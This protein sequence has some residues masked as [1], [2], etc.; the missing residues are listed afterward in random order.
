MSPLYLCEYLTTI[1]VKDTFDKTTATFRQWTKNRK[2]Q[3]PTFLIFDEGLCWR[4]RWLL[5][6]KRWLEPV[7]V[8]SSTPLMGPLSVLLSPLLNQDRPM[9]RQNQHQWS[10][11]SRRQ[12]Q[13]KTDRPILTAVR[14]RNWMT[15]GGDNVFGPPFACSISAAIPASNVGRRSIERVEIPGRCVANRTTAKW[16]SNDWGF[17]SD[18][19]VCRTQ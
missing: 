19:R 15:C 5:C 17:L 16:Y 8:P 1:N 9:H 13:S 4:R 3:Q 10:H 6:W 12:T 11:Q 18:S 14:S 2:S 7:S